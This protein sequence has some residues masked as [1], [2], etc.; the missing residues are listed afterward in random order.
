MEKQ[1]YIYAVGSLSR[2]ANPAH[3]QVLLAQLDDEL[4]GHYLNPAAAEVLAMPASKRGWRTV[5][6][7]TREDLK[8]AQE[9]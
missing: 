1:Q 4:P 8:N 2:H 9:S 5:I 7:Q 6:L 3:F